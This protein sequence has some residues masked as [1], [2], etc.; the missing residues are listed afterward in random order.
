MRSGA[1]RHHSQAYADVLLLL[2]WLLWLLTLQ[3]LMPLLSLL[4]WLPLLPLR[5][6]RLLRRFFE[7]LVVVLLLVVL[8]LLLLQRRRRGGILLRRVLLLMVLLRRRLRLRIG[9]KRHGWWCWLL[10]LLLLLPRN[11]ER[12]SRH[13]QGSAAWCATHAMRSVGKSKWDGT[14]LSQLHRLHRLHRVLLSL[15][16]LLCDLLPLCLLL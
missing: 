6:A 2:L 10:R 9:H 12:H 4:P 7:L 15:W 11:V 14:G 8:L 13:G 5:L 1:P 16:M 3:S